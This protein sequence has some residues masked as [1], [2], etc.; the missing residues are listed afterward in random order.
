[1]VEV[2]DAA[3]ASLKGEPGLEFTSQAAL[4]CRR[5]LERL[6]DVLYPPRE[7]A[8]GERKLGKTQYVNRLWAYVEQSLGPD[9]SRSALSEI[10]NRMESL[11]ALANKGLHDD[12]PVDE[13]DR[14]V[15]NLVLLTHDLMRLTPPTGDASSSYSKLQIAEITKMQSHID[16]HSNS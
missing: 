7:T 5:F 6:A 16:G 13:M 4:S 11:N 14:L 15:L 10:G 12:I 9:G 8:E 3:L 1:M 2:L